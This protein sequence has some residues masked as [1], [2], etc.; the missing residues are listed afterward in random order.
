MAT[1]GM[2]DPRMSFDGVVRFAYAR[3]DALRAEAAR[4]DGLL[5]VYARHFRARQELRCVPAEDHHDMLDD[6][7]CGCAACVDWTLRREEF[8]AAG[9]LLPKGHRWSTCLCET[10]RFIGRVHLNF[11]AAT[12]RR[13]LLIEMAFYAK[14]HSIYPHHVMAWHED[15]LRRPG[16][17]VNWCAQEMSRFPMAHWL[18]KCEAAV[19]PVVSGMVFREDVFER[20]A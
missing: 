9:M 2:R 4:L 3:L 12:N 5:G 16:Y 1:P 6:A 13:D 11:L 15:E 7:D 10:C 8:V 20:A 19:G 17:T 18:R 14:H